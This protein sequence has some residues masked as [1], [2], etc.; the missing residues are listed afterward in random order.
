MIRFFLNEDPE[1]LSDY[2]WI[3]RVK[4]IIWLHKKFKPYTVK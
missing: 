3:A 2:E 4:D 1:K